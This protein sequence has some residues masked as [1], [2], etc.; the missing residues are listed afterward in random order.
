MAYQLLSTFTNAATWIRRDATT[1]WATPGGD[2]AAQEAAP[3]QSADSA[4]EAKWGAW[5]ITDLARRWQAGTTPNAGLLFRTAEWNN[6]PWPNTPAY[7]EPV[8]MDNT[9]LVVTY[10]TPDA[11]P[12]GV[13]A[14]GDIVELPDDY[15]NG[16]DAP[17]AAVAADDD[18]SGIA[19]VGVSEVGGGELAGVNVDCG[20]PRRCPIDHVEGFDVPLTGLAAGKHVLQATARDDSG[21]AG[22]SE[23]WAIY[24]DRQAPAAATN[25]RASK[26]DGQPTRLYWTQP[27]DPDLPDGNPGSGTTDSRYRY[28]V[29]L[30]AWTDW[31][32]S[33]DSGVD[34]QAAVGTRID[35]EVTSI[36]A[37]G[38]TG[39]AAS[40]TLTVT[41]NDGSATAGAS[42]TL[43]TGSPAQRAAEE[44]PPPNNQ[45]ITF[46]CAAV[47]HIEQI[48]FGKGTY[49]DGNA[50]RDYGYIRCWNNAETPVL[51]AQVATATQ[52][53]K[54]CI[55]VQRPV[56][57]SPVTVKCRT[58]VARPP[59]TASPTIGRDTQIRA[60]SGLC[61]A[62][63][64]KYGVTVTLTPN[65]IKD[66]GPAP[67]PLELDQP[68]D[69]NEAGAWRVLANR[70]KGDASYQLGLNIDGSGHL[71][72]PLPA[73][74]DGPHCDD[75]PD[76][77]TSTKRR[78]WAAHHIVPGGE[79][80]ERNTYPD[81]NRAE[82]YA[83]A[84]GQR[85]NDPPNGAWLRSF[86]LRWPKGGYKALSEPEE[87]D[88]PN[89]D[90][91][92]KTEY[93]KAVA[94]RLYQFVNA[95]DSC[96]SA[97]SQPLVDELQEI[98]REVIFG[99]FSGIPAAAKER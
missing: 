81:A 89:H 59:V 9:Q 17:S 49:D 25:F 99:N 6:P 28:R 40:A 24:I 44:Q 31:A 12:P 13:D 74:C 95:D 62:G 70:G 68:F 26:L 48:R 66:V 7:A 36:D 61:V 57:L 11:A 41:A 77:G 22:V 73:R 83:Y 5:D 98:K 87:R 96:K 69:C 14:A 46:Y 10:T 78:G 82:T 4:E 86:S 3:A 60:P 33:E 30:G 56:P 38:N 65:G 18:A 67:E 21:K 75:L 43:E 53:F 92:H 2:S 88:R 8:E 91:I 15:S 54:I 47:H 27:Q 1:S 85:P 50:V 52:T 39:S 72:D 90:N 76:H 32:Q 20:T 29:A 19:H 45:L 58:T 16:Q 79:H 42:Q 37:V 64:Q 35:V 71:M 51:E 93:F 94:D 34:V 55:T 80:R 84:C 97:S 63:N 23:S